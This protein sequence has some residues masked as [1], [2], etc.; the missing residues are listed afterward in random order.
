MFNNVFLHFSGDK[1][2]NTDI[3]KQ[4]YWY[5]F[6]IRLSLFQ[7]FFTNFFNSSPHSSFIKPKNDHPYYIDL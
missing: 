1:K 7:P 4:Q 5:V 2:H 3:A 6:K